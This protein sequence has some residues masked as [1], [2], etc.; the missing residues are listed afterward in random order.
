[1]LLQRASHCNGSGTFTVVSE[2]RAQF[3]ASD[4]QRRLSVRGAGGGVCRDGGP[5]QG[6]GSDRDCIGTTRSNSRMILLQL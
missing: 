5:W 1:M 6:G 2:A 4:G 3:R